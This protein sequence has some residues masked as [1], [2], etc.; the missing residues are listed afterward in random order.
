MELCVNSKQQSHRTSTE[1]TSFFST[2]DEPEDLSQWLHRKNLDASKDAQESVNERLQVFHQIVQG[3]EHLH[4]HGL[5]HR[6]LKPENVFMKQNMP[7]IGDFGLA[8]CMHDP[9]H[10]L[11]MM[12]SM[13]FEEIE[14]SILQ[15][16]TT[17]L[18]TFLYASPEQLGVSKTKASYSE[19]VCCI[20]CTDRL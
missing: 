18:G 1:S 6:D 17:A 12:K 13:S 14:A 15:N 19:L 2:A 20:S 9:D 7:K 16:H 4:S 3:V 5:I 11:M 10:Y 8:K